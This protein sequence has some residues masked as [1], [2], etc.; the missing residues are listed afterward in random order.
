MRAS[1]VRLPQLHKIYTIK[2]NSKVISDK[3]NPINLETGLR[4]NSAGIPYTLKDWGYGVSNF[5]ASWNH[6]LDGGGCCLLYL[7]TARGLGPQESRIRKIGSGFV[8]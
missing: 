7:D 2:I 6:D 4:P 1:Q 5:W 8:P 3:G